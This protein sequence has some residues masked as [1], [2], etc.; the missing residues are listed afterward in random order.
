MCGCYVNL[1]VAEAERHFLIHKMH[2]KFERSYNVA[3][4]QQ[5]LL[6]RMADGARERHYVAL[7]A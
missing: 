5:V 6:A 3:P 4:T 1:D 2:W 7:G